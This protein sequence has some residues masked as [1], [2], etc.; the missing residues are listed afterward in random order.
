MASYL[1]WR[2][3]GAIYLAALLMVTLAVAFAAPAR[4][5]HPAGSC[6][7]VTP[8]SATSAVGSVHTITATL[9]TLNNG[10]CNGQAISPSAEISIGVWV[11]SGPNAADLD[12]AGN[13][14]IGPGQTSCTNGYQARD[15]G[16]DTIVGWID[17]D[18]DE[19]PDPDEPYDEVRMTWTST[20]GTG[21][22]L[23][24]DDSSG[25]DAAT[26]TG[27]QTETYTCRLTD[28]D[29]NGDGVRDPVGGI[30][31][32][33]ENLA[34]PNDPDDSSA[35]GTADRNNACTTSSAGSCNVT[36]SASEAQTGTATYCFWADTD[37]DTEFNPSGVAA[38]GGGCLGE[39]ASAEDLD[40]IDVVTLTR[41]AA[42][43]PTPARTIACPEDAVYGVG[44][45][46]NFD[47]F[48]TDS[49]GTAEGGESVTIT[50]SGAGQLNTPS[51]LTTDST[52]RVTISATSS[53]EG[54]QTIT[55][56]LTDDLTGAEPGEVDECDK[57]ANDPSGAP[58][59]VCSDSMAITWTVMPQIC[60]T[61]GAIIGTEASEEI[62]GT[63]GDDVI[64]SLGGDD[65]VQ[66][67]LG[68]DMI[69]AGAGDDTAW[70]GDG[71]D[72]LGGGAGSDTL[73]G[74]AG[75]DRL[76]GGGS[77]DFLLGGSGR[78]SLNGNAGRDTLDGGSGPDFCAD[79][80]RKNNLRS[81]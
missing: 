18:G 3:R 59:G 68:S 13:C 5:A 76:T 4:A 44:G 27:Q 65:S 78:D 6:V 74:E 77:S 60:L 26:K 1:S 64:C 69:L 14:L 42:P 67:L 54:V 34:G 23:D 81:C 55:V 11:R 48:V 31:I 32:D 47:C 53:A 7:D 75:D 45:Q 19:V 9:R 15:A 72:S 58:Q 61:D 8:E 39:A 30:A 43:A 2:A 21:L 10:V 80:P 40:Q 29:T 41:N 71:N 70:G 50:T 12:G 35:A 37:R 38:D 56:T 20:G 25:D 46:F 62:A 51:P 63:D 17:H 66:G 33:Y 79:S 24:C 36:L 49:T 73:D 57:A 52:G 28:T 16:T 22:A